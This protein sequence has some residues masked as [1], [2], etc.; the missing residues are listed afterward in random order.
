MDFRE[1]LKDDYYN[2]LGISIDS[3]ADEINKAYK[4]LAKMCHP[5]IF[6]LNSRERLKA[7]KKFKQVLQARETLLDPEKRSEYDDKRQILQDCYLFSMANL[8]LVS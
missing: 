2:L 3:T 6:P 4:Q 8:S 1:W 5:D 7:E